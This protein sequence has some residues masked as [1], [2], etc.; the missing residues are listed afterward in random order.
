MA[1]TWITDLRHY[2]D[3]RGR[4]DHLPGP[5]LGIARHLASIVAWTSATQGAGT[6]R[7]NV[8]CRRRPN[9]RRCTGEIHAGIDADGEAVVWYCPACG[10]NGEIRGWHETRWD[11]SPHGTDRSLPL[12]EIPSPLGPAGSERVLRDIQRAMEDRD[13]NSMEEAQE[14]LNQFVGRPVPHGDPGDDALTRAM[15][16]VIEAMETETAE[17]AIALARQALEVSP[18]CSD[19]Y[20][21]LSDIDTETQEAEMALVEEAVRAG[22]RA[23]GPDAFEED[24]GHFWGLVTTRPYMRA[25]L[26]LAELLS[27]R[28]EHDQAIDHCRE[29]LRLNPNDNQGVRYQLCDLF[30]EIGNDEEVLKLLGQYKN[31]ASAEWSYCLALVLFRTEGESE[32]ANSALDEALEFN[33]HVP[34]FLL[35]RKAIF[36]YI[37]EYVRPHSEEEAAG[38]ALS[39]IQHWRETY[40][41][42]RWL[43]QRTP[44]RFSSR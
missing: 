11:R 17:E 2:L 27:I 5:A 8:T 43:R 13:F 35:G 22:E 21:L 6:Q 29:L 32:A 23:L 10:D 42:V 3:D 34:A 41:A 36:D 37:T 25:R 26:R 33:P 12:P 24:V 30:F 14:F 15:D 31:D 1:D 38:Y 19:A 18:D 44:S 4:M 20:L 9:K 39:G 40:G 28:G 7:T 16:L